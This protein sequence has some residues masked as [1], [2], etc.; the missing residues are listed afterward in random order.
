MF[1][2]PISRH[3]KVSPIYKQIYQWFQQEILSGRLSANT[4]LPSK[5]SL[6]ET[7]SVSQNSV[8]SAYMQLHAEGY[9]Y[10]AERKGYFVERLEPLSLGA[11]SLPAA[12]EPAPPSAQD[13]TYSFSHMSVD[14][15]RFPFKQWRK[16]EQAAADASLDSWCDIDPPAGAER[17]RTAISYSVRQMRGVECRPEQIIIGASTQALL[18]LLVHLLGPDR[19]YALE[20]PGYQRIRLLLEK[21]GQRTELL[22]VDRHGLQTKALQN[23]AS[24]TVIVTPS[25][26]M[27]LG[28]IMPV[29][30]RIQLLNWCYEKADRYI[31]EDDYDSEFRY[32]GDMI[33]ALQSLDKQDR[34]VYMGTYSKSLLPG[35]RISYMVLPP[36]LAAAFQEEGTHLIQTASSLHQQT[37]AR[38]IETGEYRKH[39]RRMSRHYGE[40]RELLIHEIHQVFGSH[41]SI[42]GEKSGLHFLLHVQTKDSLA[43]ILGRA[44]AGKLELYGID[45][46]MKYPEQAPATLVIGFARL[47]K[48]SL[49]EAVRALHRACFPSLEG[50]GRL[51]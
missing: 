14:A 51:T 9:I 48:A 26:Q 2:I 24:D 25:H 30:R 5:R 36:A 8:L 10:T 18:Q 17:L 44:A 29:S 43:S 1:Y 38:F 39:V 28:S 11:P 6:A 16:A 19:S 4:Q 49:P 32:E 27:P 37:L 3:D 23:T 33:P 47:E 31:I 7:L 50:S 46:F 40:I 42:Q 15:F 45:R 20:D 41:A 34:V 12:N 13:Y 35:L 22:P 21:S